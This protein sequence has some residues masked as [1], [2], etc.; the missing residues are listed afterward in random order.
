MVILYTIIH[1]GIKANF[2]GQ[3]NTYTLYL[4][5][6]ILE[7]KEQVFKTLMRGE[8]RILSDLASCLIQAAASNV[9]HPFHNIMV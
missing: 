8:S 3:T 4:N 7:T 2:I 1:D 9:T 6:F 5:L